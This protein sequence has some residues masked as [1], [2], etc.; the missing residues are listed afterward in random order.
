MGCAEQPTHDRGN[1]A[2]GYLGCREQNVPFCVPCGWHRIYAREKSIGRDGE[3]VVDK[4]GPPI[5]ILPIAPLELWPEGDIDVRG[6]A[7]WSLTADGPMRRNVVE[8]RFNV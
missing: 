1:L 7:W 4:P 8:F 5:L 2:F 6:R 3:F